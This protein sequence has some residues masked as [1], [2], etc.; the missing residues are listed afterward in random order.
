METPQLYQRAMEGFAARVHAVDEGCWT[1]PTPCQEWDV[2]VLV[3]HIVGENLWAPPLFA[4]RTVAEVGDVFDGDLLGDDPV[5]AFDDSAD[6]ALAAVRE[7]GAMDRIVH[8]S[9]G[10]VPGSEYTMQLFA[11]LLVHS[12]DLARATGG[13]D[14]LDPELVAACA[15]WFAEYEDAYRA[16]GAVGARPEVP[17]DAGPQTRLLAAFGRSFAV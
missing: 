1:L 7:P 12:W 5:G 15:G 2:R 13:D 14:R 10:D 9:F 4:G 16:A 17:P 8:L 11:D 3:N 6:K